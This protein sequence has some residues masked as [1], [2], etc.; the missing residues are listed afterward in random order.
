MVE[1]HTSL[2]SFFLQVLSY[3]LGGGVGGGERGREEIARYIMVY[4]MIVLAKSKK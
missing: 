2:S 1:V 3:F 4:K